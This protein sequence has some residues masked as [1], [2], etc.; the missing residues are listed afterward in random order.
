MHSKGILFFGS[1]TSSLPWYCTRLIFIIGRVLLHSRLLFVTGDKTVPPCPKI[2]SPSKRTVRDFFEVD[3]DDAE[4]DY[5]T[6]INKMI[7]KVKKLIYSSKY[8]RTGI[9]SEGLS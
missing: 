1:C 6:R 7:L 4:E 2:Y 3:D 5:H 9:R 8:S